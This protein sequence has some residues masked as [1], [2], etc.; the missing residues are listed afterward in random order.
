MAAYGFNWVDYDY[1]DDTDILSVDVEADAIVIPV[2]PGIAVGNGLDKAFDDKTRGEFAKMRERL[3]H[4]PDTLDRWHKK[5]YVGIVDCNYAF[6]RRLKYLIMVVADYD[7]K[8]ADYSNY[9]LTGYYQEAI[10]LFA[11]KGGGVIKFPLLCSGHLKVDPEVSWRCARY[12]MWYADKNINCN[13]KVEICQKSSSIISREDTRK[14]EIEYLKKQGIDYDE[15]EKYY[16]TIREYT[17]IDID[18]TIVKPRAFNAYDRWFWDTVE[19]TEAQFYKIETKKE[20][21]GHARK[22]LKEMIS[23][24]CHSN[25]YDEGDEVYYKLADYMDISLETFKDIIIR[26]KNGFTRDNAILLS[27]AMGLDYINKLKLL[28]Y[29]GRMNNDWFTSWHYPLYSIEYEVEEYINNV[30]DRK[31]IIPSIHEINEHIKKTTGSSLYMWVKGHDKDI[32]C[33]EFNRVV[34]PQINTKTMDDSIIIIKKRRR[35]LKDLDNA[36]DKSRLF[37]FV[38]ET[39]ALNSEVKPKYR[40]SYLS[41]KLREWMVNEKPR[42]N[43]S[44]LSERL[45]GEVTPQTIGNILNCNTSSPSRDIVLG[46]GIEMGLDRDEMNRFILCSSENE[47]YYPSGEK[48]KKIYEFVE[49]YRIE[50]GCA[51]SY[52]EVVSALKIKIIH[53][54]EKNVK[55]KKERER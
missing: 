7:H 44:K 41:N 53:P 6:D 54:R 11:N 36:I 5:G 17:G 49:N 35:H 32:S 21:K 28:V 51:P 30:Y 42:I 37:G 29:A 22:K 3:L 46:I 31:K 2:N 27:L 55:G 12:G 19:K 15:F 33:I 25:N 4:D 16:S 18:Y 50:N 47:S 45:R 10:Q 1:H 24:W 13:V 8:K 43:N 26:G 20:K 39:I 48:E 52:K 14:F 9:V 38:G 40:I 23:E 34:K